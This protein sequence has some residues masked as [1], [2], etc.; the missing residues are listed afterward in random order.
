MSHVCGSFYRGLLPPP[1]IPRIPPK[2]ASKRA[3][4]PLPRH[5]L[6]AKNFPCRNEGRNKDRF[7]YLVQ[8]GKSVFFCGTN[9]PGAMRSEREKGGNPALRESR[10][11]GSGTPLVTFVVKRKSPGCRA[12]QGHALA[13]RLHWR[14]RDFRPCKIPRGGGAEHPQMGGAEAKSNDLLPRGSAPRI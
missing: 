12:W 4:I 3:T 13:E 11:V 2:V 5:G 1:P 7:A 6:T 8:S 14:S 10:T 9:Q